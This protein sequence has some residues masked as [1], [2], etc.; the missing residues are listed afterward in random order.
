MTII[1]NILYCEVITNTGP[2]LSGASG[3][4]GLAI[5]VTRRTKTGVYRG[6]LTKTNALVNGGKHIFIIHRTQIYY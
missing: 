1:C 5:C 4:N 3:N 2:F 6:Q